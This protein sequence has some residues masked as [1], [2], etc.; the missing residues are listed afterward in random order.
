MVVQAHRTVSATVGLLLL[1]TLWTSTAAIAQAKVRRPPLLEVRGVLTRI[2]KVRKLRLPELKLLRPLPGQTQGE[3]GQAGPTTEPRH[4]EETGRA[5][6]FYE[7]PF[8]EDDLPTLWDEERL[9]GPPPMRVVVAHAFSPSGSMIWHLRHIVE[10]RGGTFVEGAITRADYAAAVS[11]ANDDWKLP[12]IGAVVYIL[13]WVDVALRRRHSHLIVSLLVDDHSAKE[14]IKGHV[15][16]YGGAPPNYVWFLEGSADPRTLNLALGPHLLRRPG[17][18]FESH[19]ESC[20][21]LAHANPWEMALQEAMVGPPRG[22]P[23]R[24]PILRPWGEDIWPSSPGSAI[25]ERRASNLRPSKCREF[26]LLG[27]NVGQNRARWR[28][29][30]GVDDRRLA[31]WMTSLPL[32]EYYFWMKASY[33][34]YKVLENYRFIEMP[35]LGE[36]AVLD[37]NGDP[38]RDDQ[39]NE[40]RQR[41]GG[42]SVG[43][44]PR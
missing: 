29:A 35:W 11:R 26:L 7:V 19:P 32:Q 13:K 18:R 31:T 6:G 36:E 30:L 17:L 8:E 23:P 9:P 22:Q 37:G 1:L 4:R 20:V 16:A 2:A 25:P 41:R 12:Q 38:L 44:A 39:G 43:V 3:P 34:P 24:V 14:F 15:R 27:C 21:I 42:R 33:Q 5:P 28:A 40:L 10:E